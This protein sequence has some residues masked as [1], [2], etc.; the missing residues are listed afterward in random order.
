[1]ENREA[2]GDIEHGLTRGKLYPKN[3]VPFC[4]VV[5]ALVDK[6]GVTNII[7]LNLCKVF[8]TS[9]HHSLVYK[10]ETQR[11]DARTTPYITNWLA[12][13]TQML[14]A[15]LYSPRG[16][17][18]F[19]FFSKLMNWA[20]LERT[21]LLSNYSK[22]VFWNSCEKQA[23]LRLADKTRQLTQTNSPP[24]RPC[25]LLPLVRENQRDHSKSILVGN[26][27][28]Q[29]QNV[30]LTFPSQRREDW[31]REKTEVHWT[32]TQWQNDLAHEKPQSQTQNPA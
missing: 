12:G 15:Q 8:H 13:H 30:Y 19:K 29:A 3:S 28:T 18:I 5:T 1:M 24:T 4:N 25:W 22:V 23:V 14:F 31:S 7:Y 20:Y 21:L 17:E 11:S 2:I 10:M 16:K 6:G 32:A 9:A 26:P 27:M